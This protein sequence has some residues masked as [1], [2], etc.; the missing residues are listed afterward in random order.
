MLAEAGGSSVLPPRDRVSTQS[1]IRVR[2]R[3]AQHHKG[4]QAT[5]STKIS[6]EVIATVTA[7][8]ISFLSGFLE[9][10][11]K[12]GRAFQQSCPSGSGTVSYITDVT[13]D[14]NSCCMWTQI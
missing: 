6:P 4:I 9:W 10:G 1:N 5:R 11:R 8:S 3:K 2:G 7:L 12:E 13:V 14:T